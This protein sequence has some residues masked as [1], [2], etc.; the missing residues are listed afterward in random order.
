MCHIVLLLPLIGLP[1][2]WILPLPAAMTIYAIL[3]LTAGWAY[4]RLASTAHQPV[5]TGRDALM[6]ASGEVISK[7]NHCIQVRIVGEIWQAQSKLPLDVADQV[8]VTGIN[9]LVLAVTPLKPGVL[10]HPQTPQEASP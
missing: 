5:L 8:E 6:H 10:P 3:S 9:G 1:I 4:L 2:F 7:A